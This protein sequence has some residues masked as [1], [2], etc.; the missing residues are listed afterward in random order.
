M[1]GINEEF[2]IKLTGKS[3]KLDDLNTMDGNEWRISNK[4]TGTFSMNNQKEKI[5][6]SGW[7]T[8]QTEN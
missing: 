8:R 3:I 1:N 7:Y 2:P 6:L 4:L 5:L